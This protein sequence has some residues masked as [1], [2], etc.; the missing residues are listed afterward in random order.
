[1]ATALWLRTI[2]HQRITRQTTEPC[3]R[4]S[5]QEALAEAC[6]RLDIA[7]PLWLDKNDREWEDFGQ[8]RFLPDAFMEAVDFD[9]MEIEFIDPDAKKKRSS[10]PR[11]A[12]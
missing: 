2:R 8:T 1:M 7:L 4:S 11:N 12:F 6:H 5:P 9:R 10:D 3:V